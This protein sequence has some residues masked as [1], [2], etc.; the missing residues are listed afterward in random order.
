MN[1]R[2][3]KPD[4]TNADLEQVA[5]Q[6]RA[7]GEEQ[8]PELVD[9]AVLSRARA[10]VE[11]RPR[12][13]S[14]NLTW[15]HGLATAGVAV[16]A[17]SLFLQMRELPPETGIPATLE[18]QRLDQVEPGAADETLA[19]SKVAP[20]KPNAAV[21]EF[22]VQSQADDAAP[23]PGQEPLEALGDERQDA[24]AQPTADPARKTEVTALGASRELVECTVGQ[25]PGLVQCQFEGKDWADANAR[26]R[27]LM[28]LRAS[29]DEAGFRLQ[30]ARFREEFPQFP[31][32]EDWSE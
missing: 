12:A 21:S 8:P 31:L 25:E 10:A 9:L 23:A 6:Y 14:F 27:E 4:T 29:G 2:D 5:A 22:R 20:A 26:F 11:K 18:L 15:V 32:P 30:L 17:L 24:D 13:W 16:L 3:E 19:E 28:A 1:P 7:L